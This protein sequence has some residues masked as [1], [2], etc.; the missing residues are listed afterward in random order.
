MIIPHGLLKPET[1]RGVIEAF[2]TQEGTEYGE[3]DVPL[4]T[5]VE[6]VQRQLDA[7]SAVIVY[8][9][10]DQSCAIV[11]K[12]SVPKAVGRAG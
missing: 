12:D 8:D 5:K 10:R 1:L 9:E 4:Q 7:G 6:Q 2:V 11:P 3:Q